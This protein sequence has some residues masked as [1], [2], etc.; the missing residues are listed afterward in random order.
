MSNNLSFKPSNS[1]L[2]H[3]EYNIESGKINIAG[4]DWILMSASTFQDLV[5]GTEKILGSGA[6]VIWL[7]AG[8]NAGE[9]FAS[10][11]IKLGMEFSELP[12]MLEEFF[13]LGGWGKIQAEINIAK[14]EATITIINSITARGAE[15]KEP[16]CHLIRGFIAGV[17]NVMFHG[18][19]ECVETKCIAKGDPHCEFRVKR[20]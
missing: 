11:L 8:K 16:I 4:E 3:I 6:Q 9:Q 20:K 15:S 5:K 17:A 18:L 1:L 2:E 19:S 12:S 13:T 14:K 10:R 7:E